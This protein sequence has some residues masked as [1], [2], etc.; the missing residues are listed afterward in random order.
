MG[1]WNVLWLKLVLM[2]HREGFSPVRHFVG[3]ETGSFYK[4]LAVL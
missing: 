2:M 1:N 3:D 4:A